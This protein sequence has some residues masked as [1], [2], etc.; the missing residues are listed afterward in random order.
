[1]SDRTTQLERQIDEFAER[2]LQAT[3]RGLGSPTLFAIVYTS[4]ASAMTMT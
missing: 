3:R 1:M 2:G 4:V